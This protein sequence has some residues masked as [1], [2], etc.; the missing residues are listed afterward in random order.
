MS[1]L[2]KGLLIGAT[3]GIAAV[4][5]IGTGGLAAAAMVGGMAA[6]GAGIGEVLSAMSWMPKEK[7]GV[8]AGP[9]S[10]NVFTN[11]RP[12][13]RAHLDIAQCNKHSQTPPPLATGSATVFINGQPAAR[14]G[15]KTGCGGDLTEGSNNVFIG[16]GTVA[17]DIVQSEDLVSDWVYAALFAVGIGSAVLLAGPIVAVCGLVGGV[18]GGVAGSWIGGKRWGDGSDGQKWSMLGGS[19]LGGILGMKGGGVLSGKEIPTSAS[20]DLSNVLGASEQKT[21]TASKANEELILRK[22][23]DPEHPPFKNGTNVTDRLLKKGD[24]VNMVIDEI[25]LA[26]LRDPDS[27]LGLGGWGTQEIFTN[28]S[29]ALE[30]MAVTSGPGGFKPNGVQYQIKLEAKSPVRILD[31]IADPQGSLPGNGAQ[32]FLDVSPALRRATFEVIEITQLPQ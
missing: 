15:D 4:A 22:I 12:A 29:E 13:A 6:A 24:T 26:E 3:I 7:T 21:I 17:T 18:V 10:S 16:G 27:T 20:S 25:Q 28:A 31:G 19:I 23:A 11:S 2:L 8:I 14:V 5:I 9:G 1:C 30:R 32:S